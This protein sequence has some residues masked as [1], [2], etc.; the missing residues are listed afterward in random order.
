MKAFT[1]TQPYASLVANGDKFIETRSW[2]TNYRGPVLIHAASTLKGVGGKNGYIEAL[3][4][5][6]D[7]ALLK[8][9]E[10]APASFP[11]ETVSPGLPLGAIIA[12][13]YI[14]DCVE[15]DESV[16]QSLEPDELAVGN[17]ADGRYAWLLRARPETDFSP[18]LCKGALGLWEFPDDEIPDRVARALRAVCHAVSY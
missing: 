9:R 4:H 15:I 8:L 10:L 16:R 5:V 11:G 13:S 7:L 6:P 18:V 12:A 1:L 14:E 3:H 2:M 17:Y